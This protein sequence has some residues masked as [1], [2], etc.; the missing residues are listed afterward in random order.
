V[1]APK[2]KNTVAKLQKKTQKRRRTGLRQVGK[3]GKKGIEKKRRKKKKTNTTK[4]AP[5]GFTDGRH[6]FVG[7]GTT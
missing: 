1:G 3:R 4:F 7:R 5:I 6:A 2:K